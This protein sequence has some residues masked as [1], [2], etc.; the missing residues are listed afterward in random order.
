[1]HKQTTIAASVAR[2]RA[3]RA[4]PCSPSIHALRT[5]LSLPIPPRGHAGRCIECLPCPAARILHTGPPIKPI[6]PDAFAAPSA[7]G[8]LKRFWDCV[9]LAHNDTG[10]HIVHLDGRILKTPGSNTLAVPRHRRALALLVA[11]EWLTQD[12]ILKPHA[13][14]LTSIVTR[15]IDA[16]A[17]DAVRAAVVEQLIKYVHTDTILYLQEQPPGLVRLQTEHW[18]PLLQWLKHEYGVDMVTTNGIAALKQSPAVVSALKAVVLGFDRIELAAFEKAV[19]ATK[20][21]VIGLALLKR[22]ISVEDA[23]NAARLE[24]LHQ[25]SVWGEVEDAHDVDRED[26]K[27]QLG[28]VSIIG[29]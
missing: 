27:R 25:I 22:H 17:D 16:L 23:A 4:V 28:A 8:G 26:L 1:M 11:A 29:L 21:F 2:I 15:A 5:L 13:L 6:K 14:P 7:G 18:T 19:M 20:S 3:V 12:P 10:D 9:T 24:V